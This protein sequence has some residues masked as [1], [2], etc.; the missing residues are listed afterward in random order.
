MDDLHKLTVLLSTSV[1]AYTDETQKAFDFSRDYFTFPLTSTGWLYLG[2]RKAFTSIYVQVT[3]GYENAVTATLTAEYW[4]GT[5][6][7]SL[8]LLVE[9]TLAFSRSG[10]IK[11]NM[12]L[13]PDLTGIDALLWEENTINSIEKFWVRIITSVTLTAAT[14]L[15]GINIIFA[16]DNDLLRKDFGIMRLLPVDEN[17]TRAT[18]H[19][20]SHVATREDIIKRLRRQGQT[21]VPDALNSTDPAVED[22][23][24]WDLLRP[25]QVN[26]AAVLGA[27]MLIYFNAADDDKGSFWA[28]YLAYK[29][30]Y[31]AAMAFYLLSIDSDDDGVE[32]TTERAQ[33]Q[34]IGIFQRR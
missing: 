23:D 11:W 27:L 32:S 5:A 2:R 16:D 3:D 7:T 24:E 26:E 6:W 31:E 20:L 25:D 19:I 22:I 28:K 17:S 12:P 4:N 8:P 33:D 34:N 21:R 29:K 1:P 15:D 30:E 10:F 9:D 13:D 14:R 18:S